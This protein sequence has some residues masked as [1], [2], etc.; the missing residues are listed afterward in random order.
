MRTRALLVSGVLA[1]AVLLAEEGKFDKTIAF[2]RGGDVKLDWAYQKCTIEGVKV[3]NYPSAFDIEKARREDP[4]DHSTIQW[5]FR[6]DNR[7]STKF[8]VKLSVEILDASGQVVKAG[9][10]SPTVSAHSADNVR[11]STKVR[12][13]EAADSPKVRLRADIVPR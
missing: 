7:S 2:P 13:V 11:I 8:D 12:T 6:I 9:D 5:E 10:K 4:N 3:V 1:A